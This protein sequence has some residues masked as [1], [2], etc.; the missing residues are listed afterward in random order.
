MTRMRIS[1]L[2][3]RRTRLARSGS[4][5]EVPS[6][7]SAIDGRAHALRSRRVSGS[8]VRC[9]ARTRRS[10]R[11][12]AATRRARRAGRSQ[13]S[14][15]ERSRQAAIPQNSRHGKGVPVVADRHHRMRQAALPHGDLLLTR[16]RSREQH[17][18]AARF[19]C[20]ACGEGE[21][22]IAMIRITHRV[23]PI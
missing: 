21:H 11:R 10:A 20:A 2:R 5:E 13:A 16:R 17:R 7:A 19:A 14:A 23:H 4:R 22:R 1:P 18:L 15:A 6:T 12:A 9:A 3:K 8:R